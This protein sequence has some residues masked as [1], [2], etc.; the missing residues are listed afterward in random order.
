MLTDFYFVGESCITVCCFFL[1]NILFFSNDLFAFLSGCSFTTHHGFLYSLP[2]NKWILQTLWLSFLMECLIRIECLFVHRILSIFVFRLKM[3]YII[4][5]FLFYL[6]LF[7]VLSFVFVVQSLH[8]TLFFSRFISASRALF[9]SFPFLLYL[10]SLSSF[11]FSTLFL[12][13]L[14]LTRAIS[15]FHYTFSIIL[16]LWFSLGISIFPCLSCILIYIF[17]STTILFFQS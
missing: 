14:S 5:L 13:S 3:F 17:V 12:F 6:F 9:P 10:L 2:D 4:R 11:S 16:T 1:Q 7:Y 15:L 8:F